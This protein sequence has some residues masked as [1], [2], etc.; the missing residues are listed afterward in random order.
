MAEEKVVLIEKPEDWLEA[1]AIKGEV[2]VNTPRGAAKFQLR[3]ISFGEW[4]EI[5]ELCP[6]PEVPKRRRGMGEVPDPED[7]DYQRAVMDNFFKQLVGA[8]DLSWQKLPGET[9]EEKEHWVRENMMK[10]GQ[11]Y[12]LHGKIMELSGRGTG[13][14]E[15][16]PSTEPA[17]LATPEDWSKLSQL[18]NYYSFARN[19]ERRRFTIKSVSSVDMKAI[20]VKCDPGK[21]PIRPQPLPDGRRSIPMPSPNDPGYMRKKK[22]MLTLKQVLTLDA[23]LSFQLPGTTPDEKQAWLNKRPAGEVQSLIV[24]TSADNQGYG[25]QADFFTGS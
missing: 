25:E 11:V 22:H 18:P 24:F 21:P 15:D 16:A 23:S 9:L 2:V 5:Q 12:A 4:N 8:I 17:V 10:E 7:P 19:G 20:D 13:Q 1:K 3:A 14:P 6:E